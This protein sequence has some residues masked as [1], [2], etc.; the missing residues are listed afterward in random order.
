M[1]EALERPARLSGRARRLALSGIA[2][3]AAMGL[4]LLCGLRFGDLRN[5]ILPVGDGPRVAL[6][7]FVEGVRNADPESLRGV[8]MPG[9]LALQ[10]ADGRVTEMRIPKVR[11]MEMTPMARLTPEE[12]AENVRM[13]IDRASSTA[14]ATVPLRD[15][16]AL[17][18]MAGRVGG[19]WKV[20]ALDAS[21]EP[22]LGRVGSGGHY[23][24]RAF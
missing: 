18:V 11:A 10:E 4:A 3:V 2:V 13:R 16:G 20:I 15:G 12:G 17:W 6:A 19:E 14:T 9:V 7:T 23:L 24:V 8:T 21:V 5:A 1:F 22:E